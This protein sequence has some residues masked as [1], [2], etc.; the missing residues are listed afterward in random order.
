MKALR[1]MQWQIPFLVAALLILACG[2]SLVRAYDAYSNSSASD[3]IG[4][5]ASCHEL[6]VGGFQ[7]RGAL[8]DAHVDSATG[9]CQLCHTQTGDIPSLNVSGEGVSCIGCHGQPLAGGGS[10]GAGLKRHHTAAGVGPDSDGLTCVDCHGTPAARPESVLPDYYSRTDVIQKNPCNTDGLEDFWNRNTGL[11]DGHGM[12]NDGDLA[13]DSLDSD[14]VT[15]TIGAVEAYD[16]VDNNC[17]TEVDEIEGVK[18][19]SALNPDRVSWN[20]QPPSGQLYDVLRSDGPTFL[21]ASADTA[22]LA[23]GT[24]A[25]FQDDL[26][27]VLLGKTFFYLV[28]NTQ[29]TDYGKRTDGNPRNYTTCP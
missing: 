23:V 20:D 3:G 25:T 8:H 4:N 26:A 10:S 9:N 16:L 1:N 27:A 7:G 5:C 29:V 19:A 14:C 2:V 6:A 17:N 15:C 28:R 21:A 24:S 13:F 12:D 11:P 18:F 22:C